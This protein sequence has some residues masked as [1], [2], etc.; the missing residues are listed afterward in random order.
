M[1]FTCAFILVSSRHIIKRRLSLEFQ[2]SMVIPLSL[3]SWL[4]ASPVLAPS[5]RDSFTNFY[6]FEIFS[7]GGQ[8]VWDTSR[9]SLCGTSQSTP[10]MGLIT[11]ISCRLLIGSPPGT[12]GWLFFKTVFM[13]ML[14]IFKI[15]YIMV[16]TPFCY[17]KTYYEIHSLCSNAHLKIRVKKS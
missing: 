12:S 9:P 6:L 4:K 3:G 17:G 7:H 8:V 11:L 5:F 1:S 14:Y 10:W 16:S 2:L 15:F 13:Y